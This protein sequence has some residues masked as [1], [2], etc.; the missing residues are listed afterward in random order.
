MSGILF[1]VQ[2]VVFP[3]WAFLMFRAL[4]GISRRHN[5]ATGQPFVGPIA[6]FSVYCAYLKDPAY[7]GERR[8]ILLFTALLLVLIILFA[9]APRT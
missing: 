6:V 3:I 7:R 5:A 1:T 9:M 4:F 8:L 2:S